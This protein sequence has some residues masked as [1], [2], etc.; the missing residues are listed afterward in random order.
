[1]IDYYQGQLTDILPA[2]FTQNP[3]MKAMS[4]ALRQGCRMLYQYTRRLYVHTA[5]DSQPE[6]VIDLLA[7]EL[8][9]QYYK[10]GLDIEAKRRLVKNTLVWYMTAGTPEAVEELVSAV[11]GGGKVQEWFEYGGQPYYF[12]VTAD[13]PLAFT[14]EKDSIFRDMLK[15]VKN[16]RSHL[17]SIEICREESLEIYAAAGQRMW[18]KPPAILAYPFNQQKTDTDEGGDVDAAAV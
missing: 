10:S 6:E 7:A 14:P 16:A 13:T 11:F 5:L 3:K 12:K 1:M 15:R 8:R 17:Q 9:T 18:Y 4:H 2:N